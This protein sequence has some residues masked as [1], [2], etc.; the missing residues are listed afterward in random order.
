MTTTKQKRYL[1]MA[2]FLLAV[3]LFFFLLPTPQTPVQHADGDMIM[4]NVRIFDGERL[5]EDHQVRIRDGLIAAVEPASADPDEAGFIDGQDG[6]LMPGLIDSHVHV[7]GSARED[8][9]RFGV[10][11]M[12]DLFTDHRQ[13]PSFKEDRDSRQPTR[14]AD[15]WSAGTLVTAEGGHGTQYGMPIPTLD[16]PDQAGSFIAERLAEGS[17]FI[18]LVYEGGEAFGFETNRLSQDSLQAAIRASHEAGVLAVT[19]IGSR[20]EARTALAAGTDGL[21]HTFSDADID[22]EIIELM[23]DQRFLIPTLTVLASVVGEGAGESLLADEGVQARLSAGQKAT[24]AM[25][26][27]TMDG[28]ARYDHAETSVRVLNEAGVPILAG[29]DAPNPG[30]ANGASLHEEMERL[31]A[32]GLSPRQALIAATA[33]PADAFGLDDRGRIKAGHRADLVLVDGN[34]LENIKDSRRIRKVW[35]NGHAVDLDPAAARAERERAAGEAVLLSDFEGDR[36]VAF[37]HDWE[38]STDQRMGGQSEV[39][40]SQEREDDVGFLRVRGEIRSGFSWPYAG[41]MWFPGDTPMAPKDLSDFGG[42]EV[43]LRADVSTLRALVFSSANQS[44]PSE[45]D[46]SVEEDWGTVR[47]RFDEF[48]G[49]D[50]TAITG[51][52]IFAGPSQGPFRFDMERVTLTPAGA[53][54][55]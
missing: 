53:G 35:K 9:L 17:D 38:S 41:V 45:I 22:E 21:V 28:P 30:T 14:R 7:F 49:I 44:M 12:I 46:L 18:K 4:G 52:G 48:D 5:L 34:P 42:L 37:G 55:D 32:A 26:F 43:R 1:I 27:P 40:V 51:F 39:A 25:R 33:A 23:K 11:G 3:L 47:I 54:N 8:A 13:L 16:D 20:E 36:S 24:L 10:T 29:S 31:V 19:H 2:G 50:H 15:V 6:F